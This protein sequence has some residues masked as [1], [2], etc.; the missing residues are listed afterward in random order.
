MLGLDFE[1]APYRF[2]IG[3]RWQTCFVSEM[4]DLMCGCCPSEAEVLVPSQIGMCKIR[5]CVSAVKHIP[6]TARI[7]DPVGC[8]GA[9]VTQ[10]AEAPRAS[11]EFLPS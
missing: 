11:A 3:E 1:F 6:S 2:N 7:D 10:V 9:Y 8:Q 4:L 5:K